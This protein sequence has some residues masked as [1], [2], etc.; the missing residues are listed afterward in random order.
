LERLSP[1][2]FGHLHQAF[3]NSPVVDGLLHQFQSSNRVNLAALSYM[4]ID[5]RVNSFR[6]QAVHTFPDDYAVLKT[7][8][9]YRLPIHRHP[10]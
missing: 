2:A 5:T 6:V 8:S 9:L 7:Q 3:T 1:E 10:S 4:Y